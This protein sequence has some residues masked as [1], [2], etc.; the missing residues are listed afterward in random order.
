M[1]IFVKR[2]T[3]SNYCNLQA[4]SWSMSMVNSVSLVQSRWYR[5]VNMC[6]ILCTT[7]HD[8]TYQKT[9]VVSNT[10]VNL[11]SCI[12]HVVLLIT[13]AIEE[14]ARVIV[15][16]QASYLPLISRRK[17]ARSTWIVKEIQ[18]ENGSR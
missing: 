1:H 17:K 16:F 18:H 6:R 13:Q 10:A 7:G 12:N 2:V 5:L 8:L 11:K 3:F 4:S 15:N 9:S 14:G